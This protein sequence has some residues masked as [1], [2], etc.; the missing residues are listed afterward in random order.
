MSGI[1]CISKLAILGMHSM[2]L[3]AGSDKRMNAD[4]LA[5]LMNASKSHVAKVAQILVKHH[6][7][8]SE[9]GPKGG[10]QLK[11]PPEQTPLLQIYEIFEG[12][13]NGSCCL[14]N[15]EKCTLLHCV[16]GGLSG[17]FTREFNDYLKKT[18]LSDITEKSGNPGNKPP[19]I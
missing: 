13:L 5:L 3:I 7:L 8:V 9:R 4:S 2:A 1:L 17:K 12:K 10:F 18:K 15:T 19:C 11:N 14:M 16:F 6:L